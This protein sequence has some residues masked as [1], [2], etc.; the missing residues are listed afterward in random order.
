VKPNPDPLDFKRKQLS[1][2]MK[3][4]RRWHPE[5]E[6]EIERLPEPEVDRILRYYTGRIYVG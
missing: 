2:A 1:N 3:A 5:Y 6:K 4:R